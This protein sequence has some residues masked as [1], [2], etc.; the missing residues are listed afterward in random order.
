MSRCR[1]CDYKI[2]STRAI[3]RVKLGVTNIVK[4]SQ[5]FQELLHVA[6]DLRLAEANV[7]VRQHSAQIVVGVWRDHV[8]DGTLLALGALLVR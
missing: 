2:V 8:Q 1:I 4:I 5:S 7:R 3:H 6:L